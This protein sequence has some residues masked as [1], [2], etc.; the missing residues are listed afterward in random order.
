MALFA[1]GRQL[2]VEGRYVEAEPALRR[3]LAV[4][5]TTDAHGVRATALGA[6][7]LVLAGL[8]R[9]D[10]GIAAADEAVRIAEAHGTR[11]RQ[12]PR[13]RE[14]DRHAPVRRPLRRR[15]PARGRRTRARPEVRDARRR[16]RRCSPD[17][18]PTRCCMLGRWDDALAMRRRQPQRHRRRLRPWMATIVAARIALRRGSDRRSRRPRR[19]GDRRRRRG[20]RLRSVHL[21]RRGRT[22]TRERSPTPADTLPPPSRRS[23]RPTTSTPSR[24]CARRRSGIEADR[25][26]LARLGGRRADADV[27]TRPERSPTS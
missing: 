5:E 16:R 1:L 23:S 12:E 18:P 24:R 20:H 26:E 25:V 27:D 11:R 3:A 7:S 9:V 13:L 4:A 22:L 8:G 19:P 6:M 14:R 2:M 15:R 10:D 17:T 21:R